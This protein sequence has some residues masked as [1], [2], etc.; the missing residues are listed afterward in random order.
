VAVAVPLSATEGGQPADSDKPRLAELEQ[1][2]VDA[3]AQEARLVAVMTLEGLR[4]W[5]F[6][7]RTTEWALPFAQAGISV[8][9]GEDPHYQGL[10]E[11]A[12]A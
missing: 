3:A 9:A 2:L 10:L 4:E 7:A 1:S 8:H 12:R 5:M 11:L 6:Y